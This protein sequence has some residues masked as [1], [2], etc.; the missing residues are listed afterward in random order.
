[1]PYI[2]EKYDSE[3]YDR[4]D[5]VA[6]DNK[7]LLTCCEHIINKKEFDDLTTEVLCWGLLKAISEKNPPQV[8]EITASDGTILRSDYYSQNCGSTFL[9]SPSHFCVSKNELVRNLDELLIEAYNDY[10]RLYNMENEVRALYPRYQA[11]LAK[12]RDAELRKKR[13]AFDKVYS[14]IISETII[15]SR[16]LQELFIKW[17][18]FDF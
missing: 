13:C 4:F 11:E 2:T 8:I 10:Q 12:C 15:T 1:M 5:I 3:I 9:T 14:S 7:E 17:R 6:M 18:T 16:S